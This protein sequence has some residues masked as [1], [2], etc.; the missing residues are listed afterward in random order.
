MFCGAVFLIGANNSVVMQYRFAAVEYVDPAHA[1]RAV[2]TVM[3]GALVAAGLGPEIGV[4]AAGLLP[5]ARH[6]GSFLVGAVLYLAALA[7][8]ALLPAPPTH[9]AA[10][11]GEGR[12]LSQVVAQPD[13]LVAVLAGIVSYAVMSFIMT[14]TPISM[15]VLDHHD[16][17]ATKWVIQGHLLA[18]YLPS[19]VSGRIVAALGLV[20]TMLAGTLV[21]AGCVAVAVF[22]GHAVTHYWW[23]LV[24]LGAGWNLLF[25]A[26]TTLLTTTYRPEE[27]FRAQAVNEFAVF[28]SQAA[29]SLLAGVALY[30]LGWERLNLASVPLL[31]LMLAGT[32]TVA[33][34]RRSPAGAA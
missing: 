30:S 23:A 21:M 5:E 16:E 12:P 24:L 6:A 19:L 11:G 28:G 22:G 8:L 31:A 27:R 2:S 26:G 13:F 25:V 32:A 29:A 33:W 15:H 34:R 20:R 10:S 7:L 3:I 4:R 1:S 9:A 14:A 18:M 17:H